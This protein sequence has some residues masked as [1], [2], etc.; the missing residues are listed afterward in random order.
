MD[1]LEKVETTRFVG[2]EFLVWLWFKSE[3]MQGDLELDGQGQVELWLDTSLTLESPVDKLEKTT[4]KGLAPSGGD[5]AKVALQ[6]GK[7]PVKARISL[8]LGEEQFAFVLDAASLARAGVQVPSVLKEDDDERFLERMSLLERLDDV[9]TALYRE[10]IQLRLSKG[11]EQEFVPALAAWARGE[12]VMT[13]DQ[14]ERLLG[15][16]QQRAA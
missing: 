9:F 6:H 3:L 7:L 1:L 12:D 5:E 11:W 16:A 8:V 2:R 14:Y 10:F 15:R 13:P 4:L